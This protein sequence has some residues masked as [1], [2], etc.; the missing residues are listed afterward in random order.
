MR[1]LGF[2]HQHCRF[3]FLLNIYDTISPELTKMRKKF[4]QDL[5]N[6]N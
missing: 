6:M 3:H 1:E 4:E 5:K 2:V